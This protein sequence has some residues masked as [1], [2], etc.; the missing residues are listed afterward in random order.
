MMTFSHEFGIGRVDD[1]QHVFRQAGMEAAHLLEWQI[2]ASRV[3]G[4]GE[5]DDAG[6]RRH[7]REDG[8]DIGALGALL[9]H[10]RRRAAGAQEDRIGEEAVLAIDA[11]VARPDIGAGD[12]ADGLVRAVEG[13]DVGGVQPM[14]RGDGL[15]QLRRR[16]VG[17]E[18]QRA[19]GGLRGSDGPGRGTE[20]VLVGRELV[21][22]GNARRR[23]ALA[24]HIGGDVHD[25]R[26]RLGARGRAR[27]GAHFTWSCGDFRES[28]WKAPLR[29]RPALARIDVDAK[30][31]S[32]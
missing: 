18:R 31:A 6:A 10:H 9:G 2:G 12:Q 17:I 28:R 30:G 29:G 3:V 7:R 1:E 5:E 11:L 26:A 32:A 27:L 15:A 25:A 8:I 16:R 22:L 23:M 14:D 13:H 24:R 20:R 21:H 4:V 19:G